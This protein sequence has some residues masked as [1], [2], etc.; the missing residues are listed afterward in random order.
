[1]L[2]VSPKTAYHN[3]RLLDSVDALT[4]AVYRELAQEVLANPEISL[5][6]RQAIAN[7]LNRA[8]HWLEMQTVG[9][10]DSY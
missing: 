5:T 8:N 10:D 1:M 6:W 2:P 9:G 7:R 3:L 4:G